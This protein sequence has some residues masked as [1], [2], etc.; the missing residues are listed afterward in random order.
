MCGVAMHKVCRTPQPHGNRFHGQEWSRRP[1]CCN[2]ALN[3]R[4]STNWVRHLRTS[5]CRAGDTALAI[6]V[7]QPWPEPMHA[8]CGYKRTK[9]T[10]LPTAPR[11][12][13]VYTVSPRCTDGWPGTY[14][15]FIDLMLPLNLKGKRSSYCNDTGDPRSTP[16]SPC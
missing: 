9:T 1:F 3:D 10:A 14:L 2:R 13:I 15:M 5:A 16:T 8:E 7:Q 11:A 4:R 6:G 12:Q